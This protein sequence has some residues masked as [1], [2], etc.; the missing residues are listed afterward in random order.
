MYACVNAGC[1]SLTNDLHILPEQLNEE[2]W[3]LELAKQDL[4]QQLHDT[5]HELSRTIAEQKRLAQNEVALLH[6][7]D[8]LRTAEHQHVE[9]RDKMRHEYEH[10]M[11]AMRKKVSQLTRDNNKLTHE[12]NSIIHHREQS[13]PAPAAQPGINTKQQ[14]QYEESLKIEIETLQSS[15]NHAHAS[16]KELETRLHAEQME[17]ANMDKLLQEAQECAASQTFWDHQPASLGDELMQAK[18]AAPPPPPTRTENQDTLF[19]HQHLPS[20][21]V[22]PEYDSSMKEWQIV[23]L[24]SFSNTL[25]EEAPIPDDDGDDDDTAN[26]EASNDQEQ[27]VEEESVVAGLPKD[28]NY[29]SLLM[30]PKSYIYAATRQSEQPLIS[31]ARATAFDFDP[32]FAS[33]HH[34]DDGSHGDTNPLSGNILATNTN[35]VPAVTRTMIGDWMIKYMRKRVGTGMSENKHKRFFW[36]HPYTRTLYWGPKEPGA[37]ADN[38]KSATIVSFRVV[39]DGLEPPS[40]LIET[41]TREIK[42]RC[43]TILAHRAWIKALHYLVVEEIPA[44]LQKSLSQSF[45]QMSAADKKPIDNGSLPFYQFSFDA[46]ASR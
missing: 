37:N 31:P 32:A 19:E 23:S 9:E 2:I 8:R 22:P 44:E 30:N 35:L 33:K 28:E 20:N 42:I 24:E 16:I 17:H 18:N 13:P 14:Q 6:E 39:P 38:A 45:L 27:G 43:L 26:L 12:K 34:D 40:I 15:L 29:G 7:L 5:S 46:A 10:E 3:N 25:N 36:V 1:I 41:R 21:Q 4:T 11:I